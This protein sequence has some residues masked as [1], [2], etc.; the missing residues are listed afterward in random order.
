MS[1]TCNGKPPVAVLV[2]CGAS[3]LTAINSILNMYDNIE[4]EPVAIGE[5]GLTTFGRFNMN[6]SLKDTKRLYPHIHGTLGFY[7]AKL[8]VKDVSI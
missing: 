3:S 7:I 8:R 2:P 6:S 1:N 4:I 5:N